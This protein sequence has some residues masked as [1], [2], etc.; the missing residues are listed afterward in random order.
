MPNFNIDDA[1]AQSTQLIKEA[2][3]FNLQREVGAAAIRLP[4]RRRIQLDR[5]NDARLGFIAGQSGMD[6]KVLDCT[7]PQ[8]FD[9]LHA[10]R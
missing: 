2:L 4:I 10:R 1:I 9:D 3:E 8:R 7:E 6:R 5:L